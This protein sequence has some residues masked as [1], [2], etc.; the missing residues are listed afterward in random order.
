MVYS[1]CF[2]PSNERESLVDD[3]AVKPSTSEETEQEMQSRRPQTKKNVGHQHAPNE[4]RPA[5]RSVT[6]AAK[7]SD[8]FTNQSIS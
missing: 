7:C 1:A 3:V 4:L 8:F 6:V 5:D 2:R